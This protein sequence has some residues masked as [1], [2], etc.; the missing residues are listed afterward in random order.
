[1]VLNQVVKRTIARQSKS[2]ILHRTF[3]DAQDHPIL[4]ATGAI[5]TGAAVYTGTVALYTALTSAATALSTGIALIATW[6]AY[7]SGIGIGFSMLGFGYYYRRS[8][9]G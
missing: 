8:I 4:C 3:K 7:A 2:K 9:F 6:A 1:M 5:V